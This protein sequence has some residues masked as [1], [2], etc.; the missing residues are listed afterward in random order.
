[1]AE[2]VRGCAILDGVS[3]GAFMALVS[4]TAMGLLGL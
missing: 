1:M 2:E 3:V 4:I